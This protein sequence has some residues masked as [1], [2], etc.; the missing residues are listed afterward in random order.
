MVKQR[1]LYKKLKNEL[2][3]DLAVVVTGARQVG[4][5]TLLR[6]LFNELP[7]DQK[8]WYDFENPLNRKFFEEIDYNDFIQK[9]VAEGIHPDKRMYIF[10]DEIQNLPEITSIIKYLIDHYKVKFVVTGS[11]SYYMRN[12]FPES[13]AGRKALYELFPLSFQE[14]LLFKGAINKLEGLNKEFKLDANIVEYEKFDQEY[15]EFVQFGGYPA[16]VLSDTVDEKR[17][18]LEGIFSSYFEKDVV[19]F[20]NFSEVDEVR[21]LI[22]L[23]VSRSGSKL[24]ITKLASSLGVARKKIYDYL[25]F[26]K[27]TYFIDLVEPYSKSMDRSKSGSKKVYFNDTGILNVLGRVTDGQL[28][29]N[30]VYNQL[31]LYK[32]GLLDTVNYFRTQKGNE[33]DFILSGSMAFEVKQHGDSRDLKNLVKLSE[34]LEIKNHYLVSKNFV[35][36]ENVENILYPQFL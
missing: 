21:D 13:L 26:L 31:K 32:E 5:T 11:S 7:D 35:Q 28:F 29:E 6:M 14:F 19:N 30:A 17:S 34:R 16:V 24:D 15:E 36:D 3:N 12:L 10:I 20:G 1:K 27:Y 8:L 22:L 9:F 18:L 23:L 25:N 2:E 33:I 4:K